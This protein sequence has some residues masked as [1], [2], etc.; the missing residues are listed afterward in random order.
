MLEEYD[1]NKKN[2]ITHVKPVNMQKKLYFHFH[3]LL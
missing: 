2:I 1:K 3:P